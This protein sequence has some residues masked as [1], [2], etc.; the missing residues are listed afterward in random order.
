MTDSTVREILREEIEGLQLLTINEVAQVLKVA[1]RTVEQLVATGQL[2]TT[3][4]GR[5]T[6]VTTGAVRAYIASNTYGA[7]DDRAAS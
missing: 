5:L 3:K 6:R 4:I 2:P 1:K 7:D